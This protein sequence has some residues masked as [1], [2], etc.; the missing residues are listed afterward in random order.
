[1]KKQ[2]LGSGDKELISQY[3]NWKKEK[4]KYINLLQTPLQERDKNINISKLASQINEL[5]RE[6]SKKSA[7]FKENTNQ[8]EYNWQ[9]VR[10]TLKQDEA[11]IE[12]IHLVRYNLKD[13]A[14]DT[15]YVALIISA[16][17][18]ES[19][20]L[21]VLENGNELEN[22]AFTFYQNNV[23]FTLDDTE[24]YHLYWKPIQDKLDSLSN[25]GYSKIY[26][27]P[28]GIYHKLNLNTLLNP[29]TQ[30]FILEEQNIK[31]ITSSRDLIEF[32]GTNRD[33]DLSKNF[34]NYEA[35]LIGYPTYN[36]NGKDTL[37]I[38]GT[39]RS[40]NGLQRVVGTQ[41]VIP[42]LE[43]T[44]VETNQINSLFDKNN[45]F[46]NLLQEKE[47]TEENIKALKNPTILHIATHGFFIQPPKGKITTMQ[48]A[49]DRSLLENP[50]LRSG[51]LLAGCQNPQVGEEDGILSAEEAMNLS[52]DSTE[53]VVLSACETG[54]GDIQNG[55]GV[56]GLQ[57]A[58]R[59]A[60]AKTI[61]M[62]LW[63]VSDDATQL[64]MTTFYKEFL[65]GKPKREAFKLAQLKLKEQYPAPYYWGAFVMVGE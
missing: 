37:K 51:L 8:R 5:E 26:F 36:L 43:G 13:E 56:Y 28:D 53:L 20:E 44:R 32:K 7:S 10:E 9:H 19:P 27:S 41:A 25:K 33:I 40:L 47:A 11:A 64:L 58:F 31:L 4:E 46:T 21:L 16:E 18:T 59:Q 63:K 54:L 39:D 62:S 22:G 3:E 45:I 48:E 1:M 34:K 35:F 65:S 55:E 38:K 61:L 60:G 23:E 15:V 24:S 42:I 29:T 50:L 30:K 14:T 2:I 49:E 52:L 57:R 17:T 6:I 12:M